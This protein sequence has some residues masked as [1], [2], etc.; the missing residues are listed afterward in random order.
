MPFVNRNTVN[1]YFESFGKGTSIVLLH[2]FS[3]NRYFW[4]HQIFPLARKYRVI[5]ID[6]RGHGLSDKPNEGY[7]IPEMALDVKAV[8][9]AAQVDQAVLVGVSLGGMIAMQLALYSPLHVMALMLTSCGTHLASGVPP[10]VWQAY[11]ERFEAAFGFMTKG[12]VSEK[13]KTEK[14]EIFEYLDSVFRI[15][16]NFT[17]ESFLASLRDP[18][19]LFNWNISEQLSKIKVPTLVLAGEADQAISVEAIRYLST[20]I[21]KA[22]LKLLT[23]VGHYYPIERPTDFNRD[24]CSILEELET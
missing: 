11:H 19:G 12:S 18:E 14:P 17:K 22:R 13:T 21:P 6:L 10:V 23:D 2:P 1:I 5:V 8:L 16:E 4:T 9:D 7:S 3:T 24:L 20:A 15:P